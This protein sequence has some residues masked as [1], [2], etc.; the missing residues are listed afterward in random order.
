MKTKIR[1]LF[2]AELAEMREYYTAVQIRGGATPKRAAEMVDTV[3]AVIEDAFKLGQLRWSIIGGRIAFDKR[4][5][6]RLED[7]AR[8]RN[9]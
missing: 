8:K 7:A 2:D 1:K 4:D 9:Q 6:Q 3:L 5:I